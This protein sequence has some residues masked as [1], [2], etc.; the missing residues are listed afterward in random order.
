MGY[1]GMHPIRRRVRIVMYEQADSI[2]GFSVMSQPTVLFLG[3]NG[4]DP[5][6]LEAVREILSTRVDAASIRGVDTEPGQNPPPKAFG[7]ADQV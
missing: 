2:P 4:H 5:V 1:A 6:R 7:R 3:G